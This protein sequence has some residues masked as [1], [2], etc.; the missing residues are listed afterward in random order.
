MCGGGGGSERAVPRNPSLLSLPWRSVGLWRGVWR[1]AFLETIL[2]LSSK[3]TQAKRDSDQTPH[4]ELV[5][6]RVSDPIQ[7]ECTTGQNDDHQHA[8]TAVGTPEEGTTLTPT[9]ANMPA[10]S[11]AR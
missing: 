11:D 9:D 3:L 1:G 5:A 7:L 2:S 6:R 8:E 10:A 4:Q